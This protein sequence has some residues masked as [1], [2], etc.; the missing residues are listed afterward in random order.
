MKMSILSS[1]NKFR[2]AGGGLLTAFLLQAGLLSTPVLAKDHYESKSYDSKYASSERRSGGGSGGSSCTASISPASSTIKAGD[3]VAFSGSVSGR[4]ARY[5]WTFAGGNPASSSNRSQTVTYAAQGDFSVSLEGSNSKGE[6]CSASARVVVEAIAPPPPTENTAPVAKNDTITTEQN[7]AVMIDVLA[8]DSDA[9]GDAL[10][11]SSVGSATSGT[12]SISGN[13]I[14]YIPGTAFSGI[15]T[16]S[17]TVSDGKGGFDSAVVTVTVNATQPPVSNISINSTSRNGYPTSDVSQLAPIQTSNHQVFAVNDLGMHCGDI[18]TRISS[19]L[20]PFNVLHAQ[21]V[22]KGVT[23]RLLGKGEAKVGYSAAS[24]PDDPTLD[25]PVELADNWS[26]YK[27]NFWDI[28]LKS[29]DP[30]YPSGILP[31]F[32][33]GDATDQGLPVPN[34]EEIYLGSGQLLATQQAMPGLGNAYTDNKP[35]VFE[36][37]VE[38]MPFFTSFPFGYTAELNLH[39]A[40]GIPLTPFDDSGRQNAYPLMRVHAEVGGLMV[41]SVDT[42]TPISGEAQCQRC[43]AASIDGGNGAATRNLADNEI[44]VSADDPATD[45]PFQ[46][47]IEWASDKNILKLHDK[48]H[49]THLITGTTEDTVAPGNGEF[50]P[51]VCQTCH[52]TPALDLAQFGPLGKENDGPLVVKDADGNPVTVSYSKANGRDQIKHKSMSNVMHGHH[53]GVTDLYGVK[54]FPDMPPAVDIANDAYGPANYDANGKRLTSV[55][56]DILDQTCYSCHPGKNTQC[57]RGAMASGGLV[58]QDCH[59]QMASVGDDFTNEVSPTN[60][61]AFHLGSD[62]YSPGSKTP[63]V[64][65]ANEPGCGS[66]H[67]GNAV[68]NIAKSSS[69]VLVNPKDRQG[70]VDGIRLAQAYRI[71]DV[72]SVPIVPAN[73]QFAENVV[74]EGVAADGNP[75][76]YRVSTGHGGLMCEAC[77]GS[78]HAEFPN[79]NPNANDNMASIQIQGHTGVISECTVCHSASAFADGGQYALSLNGPHGMHP[80]GS[81]YW[82]D[83]HKEAR[84][85]ADCK[86]CHGSDGNGTVLSRMSQDRRLQCEDGGDMGCSGGYVTLKKGHAVGCNDCHRNMINSSGD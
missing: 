43:H 17:Y 44:A 52:Y 31:L 30:F 53:A 4:R 45:V 33:S 60:P 46:A 3:S 22:Q 38:T 47:S 66:C 23:P 6:S 41:S 74:N 16:F 37:Y 77:H 59:G 29:Y 83:H 57:M 15:S 63:R 8:N 14:N 50:T 68:D 84:G 32:Y 35:Q 67:T 78:T 49:G 27:T 40:A 75:K 25:N 2:F 79:A 11:V 18:D 9:D 69:D 54:L 42:V 51:V 73:R 24:N 71:N 10:S 5:S 36:S 39:E 20:P 1:N 28:A 70:N 64:P 82:N 76:L 58:C 72:R 12:A 7:T 86:T 61:G 62:Y 19:I 13:Q 65:W 85:R 26:V 56:M 55:T 80:V 34:I 48:K 21:V 81:S